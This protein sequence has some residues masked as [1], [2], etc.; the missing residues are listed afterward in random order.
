MVCVYSVYR[1]KKN[2]YRTD[3]TDDDQKSYAFTPTYGD[4]STAFQLHMMSVVMFSSFKKLQSMLVDY[5]VTDIGCFDDYSDAAPHAK[6]MSGNGI[7]SFLL[8]IF[9]CIIVNKKKFVT[10]T[11]IYKGRLSRFIQG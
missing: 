6:T 9:Q 1:P 5:S 10:A 4:V 8:H 11:L 3:I 2:A 7:T